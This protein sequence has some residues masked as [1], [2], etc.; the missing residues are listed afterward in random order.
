MVDVGVYLDS[1]TGK[2]VI[3]QVNSDYKPHK[4]TKT[5]ANEPPCDPNNALATLKSPDRKDQT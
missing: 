5:K 2:P 1:N 3:D 4:P